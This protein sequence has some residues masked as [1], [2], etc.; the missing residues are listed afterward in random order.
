MKLTRGDLQLRRPYNPATG[1]GK[2]A[3]MSRDDGYFNV[4]D[5]GPVGTKNDTATIAAAVAAAKATITTWGSKGLYFPP[6]TNYTVNE[7]NR[8]PRDQQRSL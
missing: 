7:P 5:F 8:L 1:F 4:A 6:G 3:A 2:S